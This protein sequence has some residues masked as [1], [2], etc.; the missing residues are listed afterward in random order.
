[1]RCHG[2]PTRILSTSSDA[3]AATLDQNSER[4]QNG[5]LSHAKSETGF[6]WDVEHDR[7]QCLKEWYS[8]LDDLRTFELTSYRN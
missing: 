3:F 5:V 4:S 6:S 1:M 8:V 2:S 7:V